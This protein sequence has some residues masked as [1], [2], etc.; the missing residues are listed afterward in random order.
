MNTACMLGEVVWMQ[1]FC[2]AANIARPK[3]SEAG[4]QAASVE[5]MG[6][7]GCSYMWGQSRLGCGVAESRDVEK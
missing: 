7:G 1:E 6:S 5:E 3:C 4:V 2:R